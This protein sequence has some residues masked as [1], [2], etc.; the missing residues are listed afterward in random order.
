MTNKDNTVNIKP[1]KARYHHGDLR[2]ALI[3]EGMAEISMKSPEE[4][5]L[6]EIARRAG[7][8]ATAVYRHFP[9][10]AALLGALCEVGSERL[11]AAFEEAMKLTP[12]GREALN[13]MGRAYV[14]F[15][16][17]NPSLFRM[18]MTYPSPGSAGDAGAPLWEARLRM[19]SRSLEGILPK[20]ASAERRRIRQLQ[21]W[22][23]V[24]GLAMLMLDGQVPADDAVIDQVVESSFV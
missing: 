22:S 10:K 23:I 2:S 14:R 1:R 20:G 13:A 8:S 17:A 11:N 24:H 12:G 7:V 21:A 5:S 15:A 6:R 18:M 4:I 3:E 9:D 16:L 19:V